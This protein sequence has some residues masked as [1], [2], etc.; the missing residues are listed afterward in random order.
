MCDHMNV[1]NLNINNIQISDGFTR[2]TCTSCGNIVK[3]DDLEFNRLYQN[4]YKLC[5]HKQYDF[6]PTYKKEGINCCMWCG[7]EI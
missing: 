2:Y 4:H 5:K 1:N 7:E 6:V 3:T